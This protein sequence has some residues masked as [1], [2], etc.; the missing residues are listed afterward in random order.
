MSRTNVLGSALRAA[1][2][3]S[4]EARK[5]RSVDTGLGKTISSDSSKGIGGER[6][7][8]IDDVIEEADG[9]IQEVPDVKEGQKKELNQKF[10]DLLDRL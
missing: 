9:V 3:M 2:E 7:R 4:N 10:L 8:K 1:E 5:I 6:D